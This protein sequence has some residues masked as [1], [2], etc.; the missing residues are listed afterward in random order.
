ML[1]SEFER[2]KISPSTGSIISVGPLGSPTEQHRLHRN[3]RNHFRSLNTSRVLVKSLTHPSNKYNDGRE[4]QQDIAPHFKPMQQ[5]ISCTRRGSALLSFDTK[6]RKP[7]RSHQN[8]CVHAFKLDSGNK[9][10]LPSRVRRRSLVYLIPV[11]FKYSVQIA[12]LLWHIALIPKQISIIIQLTPCHNMTIC[13]GNGRGRKRFLQMCLFGVKL[14]EMSAMS[15]MEH[16]TVTR[17]PVEVHFLFS[18]LFY[19]SDVTYMW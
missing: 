19:P 7:C 6:W 12:V 4:A 1:S 9:K 16:I 13:W 2:G 8:E 11:L 3:R 18:G 10:N 14:I 5:N 17:L 15:A